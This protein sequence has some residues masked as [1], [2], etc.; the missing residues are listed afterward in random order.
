MGVRKAISNEKKQLLLRILVPIM[1]VLGVFALMMAVFAGLSASQTEKL[2]NDHEIKVVA[3]ALKHDLE[4]LDEFVG[5]YAWWD[6][7]YRA[8]QGDPDPEWAGPESKF[9]GEYLAQ[10]DISE[11][12]IYREG[13]GMIYEWFASDDT[14]PEPIALDQEPAIQRMIERALA[15]PDRNGPVSVSEILMLQGAIHLASASR[16]EPA[17]DELR[18]KRS[19]PRIIFIALTD[20]DSAQI[21]ALGE[22][23]GLTNMTVTHGPAP[24]GPHLAIRGHYG[25]ALG[26]LSWTSPKSASEVLWAFAP[27][28]TACLLGLL[29]VTLWICRGW[30][31]FAERF[32]RIVAAADAANAASEAKSAFI[33]NMSHELRTPLNAVIG[34]SEMIE[35][36]VFGPD[37][38]ERYASYAGDIRRSGQHLLSLI[39]D[40]LTVAKLE[41]RQ[42]P[43]TLEPFSLCEMADVVRQDI[44]AVCAECNIR[45]GLPNNLA[46]RWVLADELALKKVLLSVVLNAV[47]FGRPG[48]NVTMSWG[49]ADRA[50]FTAISVRDDGQ[51]IDG[52]SLPLIGL[53]FFQ[54]APVFARQTGGLG[55]GLSISRGLAEAMGGELRI[56]TTPGGGATVTILLPATRAP[57]LRARAA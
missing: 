9:L 57:G 16:V 54:L 35:G 25:E 15:Q 39:N 5:D 49:A 19:G 12:L 22:D 7:F 21:G 40:I 30:I 13:S 11:A 24:S 55:L 18:A 45:F 23:F 14:Y 44:D 3:S 51:G 10:Y 26:Y 48:G 56:G 52:D 50:G 46:D 4:S 1:S 17:D 38:G 53:P 28:A 37:Q 27:A 6:D 32:Q 41:A 8:F 42:Y 29:V 31:G 2:S 33:A 34:F 20:L 36:Q 43:L 47:K